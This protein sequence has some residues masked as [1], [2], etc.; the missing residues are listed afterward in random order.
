[1]ELVHSALSILILQPLSF[2]CHIFASSSPFCQFS[3]SSLPPRFHLSHFSANF[4]SLFYHFLLPLL[5]FCHLCHFFRFLPPFCPRS[6]TS[7]PTFC[8][9]SSV[10]LLLNSFLQPQLLSYHLCQCC[11]L[12]STF[13]YH[14]FISSVLPQPLFCHRCLFSST[15]TAP[16]LLLHHLCHFSAAAEYLTKGKAGLAR[17]IQKM[18]GPKNL[19]TQL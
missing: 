7:L 19:I 6:A 13:F 14:L 16:L 1:M 17:P 11:H 10:C 8:Y 4:S 9:L 12:S 2:F 5:L 18:N 3:V 15:S